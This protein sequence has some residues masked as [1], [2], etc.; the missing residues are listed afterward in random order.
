MNLSDSALLL[1]AAVTAPQGVEDTLA[2]GAIDAVRSMGMSVPQDVS[3]VGFDDLPQASHSFPGLTTVR[4]PLHDMGQ[5]A[6]RSIESQLEGSGPLM[7]RMQFATTLIVRGS[8]A[9]PR[10][11][12][13]RAID[14]ALS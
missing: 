8:T 5:L 6:A 7:E 12:G 13:T 9:H 4:Q 1:F 3:V 10:T 14:G 11:M 2:I